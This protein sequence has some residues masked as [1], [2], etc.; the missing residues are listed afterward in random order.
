M[1]GIIDSENKDAVIPAYVKAKNEEIRMFLSRDY[2]NT[3]FVQKYGSVDWGKIYHSVQN[4]KKYH[5]G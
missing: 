3:E 4:K 2:S 1:L 5:V